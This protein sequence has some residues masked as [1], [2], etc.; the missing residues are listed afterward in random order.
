MRI[1]IL[2]NFGL[3]L[4]KF[5]KELLEELINNHEVYFSIPNDEYVELIEDIGCKYIDNPFLFRRGT[6]P[7]QD[8]RLLYYYKRIIK[9]INPS[10]VFTFTI[11]PNVYGGMAC[12]SLGIP[13]VANITGLGTAVEKRGI[14]QLVT[15]LLYKH[16]LRKAQKVFFQNY[17][18]QTF[19][20]K[21]K[22][23][24][25]AYD[26]IPGSGVNLNQYNAL[27]YPNSGSVN[28]V[29]V[30]RIMKE[31]G[32][33]QYLDAAQAL[34]PKYPTSYFHICGF[35]EQ[36]YESVIHKL[37]AEGIIIY[38]GMVSDMIPIYINS[39]CIVHPSYYPEGLSNVLLEGTASARPLIT[40]NRS[41]CKEVVD[42][43]VNGYLI[44]EKDSQDLINKLELFI[45]SDWET[46]KKMGLA[47]RV[48]VEREFDRSFVVNKYLSEISSI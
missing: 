4:Y 6:N 41:G 43:G 33:E 20:L 26:L 24:S 21:H 17:E 44:K 2:A 12:A 8:L 37:E 47:G 15:L 19:M 29:F 9:Q 38:H 23:V 11:K 13:Y 34:K 32:I 39:S 5:R 36:D 16:G 30:A 3:G 27:P 14:L 18:N 10:I 28:F 1:L 7:I 31:K 46:R 40:T 42:D 45:N 35:C 25:G 48:K 22:V